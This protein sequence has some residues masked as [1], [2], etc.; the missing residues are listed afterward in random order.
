MLSIK[1]LFDLALILLCTKLLGLATRN[2]QMPQVV[3]ALIAGIILGPSVLGIVGETDFISKLAEL[4]VIV[5]M[6]QAG[7]ETDL[8]EVKKCGKASFVIALIGVLVPLSGGFLLGMIFN[9]DGNIFSI[10]N[11]KL[12]ENIFMGLIL[13]ATSVSITVETLQEMGKLRTNSGVAIMSAAIIDDIIGIVLL[14]IVTS[15]RDSSVRIDIVL[16]RVLLFFIFS[17]LIG[18]L[19]RELFHILIAHHGPKKRIAIFAF[20]FCLILS[21]LAEEYFGI[22]NITGAYIAGMVLSNMYHSEYIENK[23]E[24]L[25]F[26]LLSPVFFAS[27]GIGITLKASDTNL[28]FFTVLLT[29]VAIFSKAWGCSLGAELCGYDKNESLQIGIGMISRGEVALIIANKGALIG[30]LSKDYFTPIVVMVVITTLITPIL[31]KFA[32][33][34][35]RFVRKHLQKA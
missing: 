25:S 13:T 33:S 10:S 3:G 14:T 26:L 16:L 34:R 1:F 8:K 9:N 18:L 23:I 17:I 5:L 32:F 29:I 35:S 28:I 27:I 6:F 21:F 30:L 7:L 24:N 11:A 12:L 22:A 15:F 20:S 31:L 2:L 4:G 19:A